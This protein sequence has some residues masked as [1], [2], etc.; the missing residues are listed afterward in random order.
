MKVLNPLTVYKNLQDVYVGYLETFWETRYKDLNDKIFKAKDPSRYVKGPYLQLSLEYEKGKTVEQLVEDGILHPKLKDIYPDLHLRQH[1]EDVILNVV[2]NNRNTLISTGTASGKTKAFLIPVFDYILKLKDQLNAKGIDTKGVKAIFLYPMNALVNDQLQELRDTLSGTGITFGRYTGDTPYTKDWMSK[3]EYSNLKKACPEELITREE[4]LEEI[5]DILIT[6]YSMLEF[7]LLRPKDTPLFHGGRWK[8]IVLDEVH[9]YD[10]AKGT[11]VGYLLRRLKINAFK[12][13]PLCIGASATMGRGTEEDLEKSADFAS[14]L[15]GEEFKKE[16]VILPVYREDIEIDDPT[17]TLWYNSLDFIEILNKYYELSDMDFKNYLL[18]LKSIS[19]L[20]RAGTKEEM[21][22]AFFKNYQGYRLIREYL[23]TEKVVPLEDFITAVST[24][25]T[26]LLDEEQL[27]AFIDL[28]YKAKKK[29][30]G[31][32]IRLLD[33]KFHIFI[34]SLE[35]IFGTIEDS[36]EIGEVFFQ[37]KLEHENRKVYQLTTCKNCG[38]MFITGYKKRKSDGNLY[39]D[40][41]PELLEDPFR[42]EMEVRRSYI[43]ISKI[44]IK[45]DNDIDFKIGRDGREIDF[46]P[47]TGIIK[48]L[49]EGTDKPFY[50]YELIPEDSPYNQPN[51]CPSCGIAGKHYKKGRWVSFFTPPD[52]YPQAVSLESVYKDL[53]DVS[54]FP[55]ER[56]IIIFSDSRRDAAFFAPFFQKFYNERWTDQIMYNQIAESEKDI[57]LKTL[58]ENCKSCVLSGFS[59]K[60]TEADKEEEIKRFKL[61]ILKDFMF[62]KEEAFESTGLVKYRLDKSIEE[63]LLKE[64]K[65]TDLKNYFSNEELKN[66]IYYIYGYIRKYKVTNNF[67]NLFTGFARSIWEEGT[68]PTTRRTGEHL[69]IDIWVPERTGYVFRLLKKT[70]NDKSGN[71]LTD[72]ELKEIL[73]QIFP[74]FIENRLGTLFVFD[75]ERGYFLDE[76]KVF[77]TWFVSKVDEVYRCDTCRKVTPWNLKGTC[78]Q[79]KC[80]GT[81]KKVSNQEIPKAVYLLRLFRNLNCK[82]ALKKK[83]RVEE[84]TAQL[85]TEYGKIVQ[86]DFSE[87]KIN[88]L[89][90]STTFELGVN[91]GDLQVVYMHNIPLRPDNYVQRAGRAGR[92]SKSAALIVSYAL[93]RPHDLKVF[94]NPLRMIKGEIKPPIIKDNNKRIILRHFNAVVLSHY[95]RNNFADYDRIKISDFIDHFNKFKSYVDSHPENIK[96]ELKKILNDHTLSSEFGVDTWQ[97]WDGKIP[98]IEDGN[99]KALLEKIHKELEEEIKEINDAIDGLEYELADLK[100]KLRRKGLSDEENKRKSFLEDLVKIYEEN[101]NEI[102]SQDI[103]TF[104]SRKVFIPKYGFPVDIASLEVKGAK[105]KLHG[106]K[107]RSFSSVVQLDRGL[108]LAIGEYAPGER[109]IVAGKMV[110]ATNVKIL[111]GLGPIE[112]SS[113]LYHYFYCRNCLY[114]SDSRSPLE[115]E[116]CPVCKKTQNFIKDRYLVPRGFE[117]RNLFSLLNVKSKQDVKSILNSR[118]YSEVE[119]LS[120]GQKLFIPVGDMD[121]DFKP[122]NL[123]RRQSFFS[124]KG[125][126]F[127]EPK[128][129][130]GFVLSAYNRGTIVTLNTSDSRRVDLK[131]GISF[132]MYSQNHIRK[133]NLENKFVNLGYR[134]YTDILFIHPP[135]RIKLELIDKAKGDPFSVYLSLLYAILEGASSALDIKREDINGMIRLNGNREDFNLILYDSVPAGAGFIEEIYEN[136]EKVLEEAK[137]IA[138]ECICSPDTVCPICL[139]HPTNQFYAGK[140]QRILASKALSLR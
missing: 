124:S 91:L 72:D 70:L 133:E 22:F 29:R 83:V 69:G 95:L 66:F 12:E 118:T 19:E 33:V 7:L 62:F 16:D 55:K 85:S 57:L 137:K 39:I 9:I 106:G 115:Y 131:R 77:D 116:E 64:L 40:I 93:N 38:E 74:A 18:G 126:R 61:E 26:P 51:K 5:P 97:W 79:D 108:D 139:L 23:K 73:K 58:A 71:S 80:S 43:Y 17:A 138:D 92:S 63:A 47:K 50:A 120:K 123:S 48:P 109:V 111:K 45:K 44:P 127:K 104:F 25:Y 60:P 130:K 88:I 3:K 136:F 24:K 54:E 1:Q 76:P 68:P 103:I 81:L 122:I 35:G 6:N 125:D 110:M 13:K 2:K 119:R 101:L 8:F 42:L 11:E 37:K 82:D 75:P 87:G 34:R 135:L 132:G 27:L 134:F 28:L 89:S 67:H 117:T 86:D 46:D 78:P 96:N 65:E 129:K 10:G 20:Y 94:E 100:K 15:F 52:E 59:K 53:V 128:E 14:R 107:E 113:E 140:L 41:E 112:E 21:L 36:G 84:H 49:S 90:C 56:K 98:S 99:S 121:R 31:N 30:K 4:I 32:E 114:F 105:I 102:Y